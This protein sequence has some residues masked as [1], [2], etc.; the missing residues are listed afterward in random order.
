ML[1]GYCGELFI[2]SSIKLYPEA[3]PTY[4]QWNICAYKV[5]L[6]S[7]PNRNYQHFHQKLSLI[8]SLPSENITGCDELSAVKGRSFLCMQQKLWYLALNTLENCISWSGP[9]AHYI[10]L[11]LQS[12]AWVWIERSEEWCV[13]VWLF[14]SDYTYT[15]LCKLQYEENGRC[16]GENRTGYFVH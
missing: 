3:G 7:T 1:N 9:G 12:T 4:W 5:E 11:F 8:S 6:C 2:M 14:F 10:S 13:G 15:M 16:T